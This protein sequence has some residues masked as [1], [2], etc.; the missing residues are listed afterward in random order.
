MTEVS[1]HLN[2]EFPPPEGR[3]HVFYL[4]RQ[5]RITLC[6]ALP[7]DNARYQQLT[8]EPGDDQKYTPAELVK[9]IREL[10]DT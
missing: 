10:M 5:K 1:E 2:E 6:L 4:D 9:G 8:L 7:N 3:H